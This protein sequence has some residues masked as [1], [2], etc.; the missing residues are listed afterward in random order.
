MKPIILM[1]F[2]LA[3]AGCG[4]SSCDQY[5]E[6]MSRECS[7]TLSDL[8]LAVCEEQ[9]DGQLGV[10]VDCLE[11]STDP[12]LAPLSECADA[13]GVLINTNP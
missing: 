4:Q 3:L 12:C 10:C 11:A 5:A 1:S 8:E 7:V 2:I 13:C 9:D 6:L